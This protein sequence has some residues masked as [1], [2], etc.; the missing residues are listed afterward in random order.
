MSWGSGGAA[1]PAGESREHHFSRNL[2][3]VRLKTRK[4]SGLAGADGHKTMRVRVVDTAKSPGRRVRAIAARTGV[5]RDDEK[6]RDIRKKGGGSV[7]TKY[8]LLIGLNSPHPR[9]FEVATDPG[10]CSALWWSVLAPRCPKPLKK[11]ENF[12]LGV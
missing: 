9:T 6:K 7:C 5:S 8:H 12:I 4:F 1:G 10:R 3:F 2:C 11:S